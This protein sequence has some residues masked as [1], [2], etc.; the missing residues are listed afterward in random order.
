MAV[1]GMLMNFPILDHIDADLDVNFVEDPAPSLHNEFAYTTGT[2]IEIK[3][4]APGF[5]SIDPTEERFGP[6]FF[7]EVVA[8]EMA[9]AILSLFTGDTLD[10][11]AALFGTTT[12]DWSPLDQPWEDR[13][14]E[15]ICETFKD[16]F[17]P[18]RYRKYANRTNHHISI[19]K[20]PEFRRIWRDGVGEMTGSL[21][22]AFEETWHDTF[23][24]S[25]FP[26]IAEWNHDGF[27]CQPDKLALI[28]ES[29]AGSNPSPPFP[30]TEEYFR[31]VD[32][33]E[34]DWFATIGIQHLRDIGDPLP[35]RLYVFYSATIGVVN[36]DGTTAPNPR[37]ATFTQHVNSGLRALWRM[38][39][40][41]FE[42]SE[43][44]PLPDVIAVA[45]SDDPAPPFE[46]T[47][48]FTTL[49]NPAG[50][51]IDAEWDVPDGA[52]QV[53]SF[54]LRTQ[55]RIDSVPG[56]YGPWYNYPNPVDANFMGYDTNEWS[57]RVAIPGFAEAGGTPIE[58]PVPLLTP[59]GDMAGV[60]RKRD[61][62]VG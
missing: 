3:R 57:F 13:P 25:Y 4:D 6:P 48:D 15:G 37:N 38:E 18:R 17:L 62:V 42:F 35:A 14:L 59:G 56:G 60:R 30:A 51:A 7:N 54:L 39:D 53:V 21:V 19:S 20:Y 32:I 40:G 33:P 8:H 1:F 12:D 28:G 26:P 49:P 36:A 11:L 16:A 46:P 50:Y 10:A 61:R 45:Q 29:D 41:S 44:V 47:W 2:S 24:D 43:E 27:A 31:C 22:P 58:L 52:V 5:D 55:L 34:G 9:H 23:A